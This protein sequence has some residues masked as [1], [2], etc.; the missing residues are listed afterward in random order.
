MQR[1]LL[2]KLCIYLLRAEP[3]A[4]IHSK[5][6]S[7]ISILLSLMSTLGEPKRK[8]F[9]A[10]RTKNFLP[11]KCFRVGLFWYKLK[12]VATIDQFYVVHENVSK[13]IFFVSILRSEFRASEVHEAWLA[14]Q[15]NRHN[16]LAAKHDREFSKNLI[17]NQQEQI[18]NWTTFVV[19]RIIASI[20]F[21]IHYK[22]N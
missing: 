1:S 9:T 7:I 14:S 11:E 2:C 20:L 12:Y 17:T 5:H 18:F 15:T 10:E 8:L 4:L 21:S 6:F 13:A 16:N 22:L 19:E 3:L